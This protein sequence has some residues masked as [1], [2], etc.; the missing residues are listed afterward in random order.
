MSCFHEHYNFL[1]PISIKYKPQ[2]YILLKLLTLIHSYISKIQT[3]HFVFNCYYWTICESI[4]Q[5]T[6]DKALRKT[7]R[8]VYTNT[9]MDD[10]QRYPWNLY[11]INMWKILSFS[12]CLIL[13]S[14]PAAEMSNSLLVRSH[15][16]KLSFLQLIRQSFQGNRC[17]SGIIIFLWRVTWIYA[18]SP[19]NN[20]DFYSP[21]DHRAKMNTEEEKDDF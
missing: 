16:W 18:Y 2:F 15:S 5:I 12:M 11:L 7:K 17:E 6:R 14:F 3:K 1:T 10:L 4:K 19:F 21:H 13:I 9:A 8:I 20:D